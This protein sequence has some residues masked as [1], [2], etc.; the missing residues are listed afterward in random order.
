MQGEG[1]RGALGVSRVQLG[2]LELLFWETRKA[3]L[4]G[5]QLET[6]WKL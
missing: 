6:G 1:A 5:L 4:R 2:T 3:V